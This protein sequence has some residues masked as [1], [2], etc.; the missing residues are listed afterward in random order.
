MTRLTA[1]DIEGISLDLKRFE[2]KLRQMTGQDMLGIAC[3]G[4]GVPQEILKNK[5]KKLRLAAVPMTCGLGLIGGFSHTLRD[6]LGHMGF[7]AFVPAHTDAAGIAQA[8]EEKADILFMADDH[9]YI[10]LNLKKSVVVDNGFA[11][12]MVF[13]AALDLMA[14]GVKD[15]PVL[16]VG[17]GPVG[18]AAAR[19][20]IRLGACLGIHDMNRAKC[21]TCCAELEKQSPRKIARVHDLSFAGRDYC[22]FV[23]ATPARDVIKTDMITPQTRI[24]AP[25]VPLGVSARGEKKAGSQILYDPLQLGTAAMAVMAAL[26]E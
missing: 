19:T 22:F 20:L 7:N 4:A 10:A 5:I 23:E 13:A 17:C 21:E 16:V 26:S 14:G 3:H 8:I 6:I 18:R 25:G 2:K 1:N 15:K 12:G 9:R 24:A 11:T